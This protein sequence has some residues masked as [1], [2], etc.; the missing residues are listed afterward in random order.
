MYGTNSFGKIILVNYDFSQS[1]LPLRCVL[2]SVNILETMELYSD[3]AYQ[4]VRLTNELK[5]PPIFNAI[6][7]EHSALIFGKTKMHRRMAFYSVLAANY[8]FQLD[9]V[10]TDRRKEGHI[11]R[12]CSRAL[13]LLKGWK[14]AESHIKSLMSFEQAQSDESTNHTP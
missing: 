6:L 11:L 1:M 13:P 5:L 3:A 10:G 4:L 7:L 2:I 9:T 12:C 14:Y 8:F